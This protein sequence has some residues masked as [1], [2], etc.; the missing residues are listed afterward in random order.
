MRHLPWIV[1]VLLLGM[2]ACLL[3]ASP[4]L[5]QSDDG[6]QT[7]PPA[8]VSVILELDAPPVA[9]IY[10]AHRHLQS[11]D[12][13]GASAES[14]DAVAAVTQ[15]HLAAVE[16][17]Q[18]ATLAALDALDVEVIYRVQRV[19]NGIAV[20]VPADQ[21]AALADL[22][23]VKA[24]HPLIAKTPSNA[25]AVDL[26]GAP[27]LWLGESIS[28]TGKGVSIGIIDTGI[29]YLHTMFGG[30]GTGYTENDPTV[31]TDSNAFPSSKIVGGYDF[32]GDDYNANVSSPQYQPVPHPDPDPRDCYGFGHG[33]HVAGTA[34]G[35]GVNSDGTTY[36]GPYSATLDLSAMRIAP[37]VAP[38]ASL[39]A[40][41]VFGCSGSSEV[42]DL[43]I[44]WAVDPNQDGDLR[45]HLDVINLSLG[46]NFG[47]TYDATSVA[48]ENA[49][50]VGVVVVASAGNAGDVH[51]AM[52]R[53]G[54]APGV[55]A[56]G[57]S[58]MPGQGG[59]P[60]EGV[61]SFSARGP[62]RGANW[63]KPDIVAPG[64]DIFSARQ[65]TG[66][67]GTASSGTSMAAPVVTGG[68]A[69]LRQVRPAVGIPGWSP[70]ELKALVMNTA[71]YPLADANGNTYS[72]LRAGAGRIDL[73]AAQA[74]HLIA[75]DMEN[76]EQ[77]S[78]NFGLVEVLGRTTTVRMIQLKNKASD[79][80]R[81]TVSYTNVRTMPGVTLEVAE[82]Q[83]IDV[84]GFG[85]ASVPV[86]L[87]A[88]AGAMQRVHD[89]VR[90][91][92]EPLS[93]PGLDEVSGYVVFA[94]VQVGPDDPPNHP[95]V[96][97]PV[98]AV[99]RPVSQLEAISAP[100]RLGDA[101][102]GT[103]TLPLIGQGITGTNPPTTTV[104]L[105]GVFEL[106]HSS[107]P[108]TAVPSG[109]PVLER[110]ANADLYHV[111][112]AG[113]VTVDDVQMIY[114]AV[115]TYGIRSTPHEVIFQIQLDTDGDNL[116]EFVLSN[117]DR[118]YALLLGLTVSD[119]FVGVLEP[120]NNAAR[121][122]QGPL[123]VYPPEVYDTRLFASNAIILPLRLEDLGDAS[124]QL[125]Y[126][127]RAFSRDVDNGATLDALIDQ[128][129][130]LVADWTHGT[131]LLQA[132]PV[133]PVEPGMTL[134][135][136]YVHHALA[137]RRTQ[138]ILLLY[139]H[140]QSENPSQVVPLELGWPHNLY[141]T[142]LHKP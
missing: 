24:V 127:V 7:S 52:S 33:T 45:D 111:G 73:P 56:V 14:A 39:Y 30:P 137:Q 28:L 87:T 125:H 2:L 34:A 90:N 58:T 100:I 42:V 55:I 48:A 62:R 54:V 118:D 22:P 44:E 38:E 46:S 133:V 141:L 19:Y 17:A 79:P 15:A 35:Y 9:H 67:F 86:T 74:A 25:Q 119:D 20:R 139:L 78:V 93:L 102:S 108:L 138:G 142:P 61:A 51:Y 120:Y 47:D 94:P 91:T 41:K 3:F 1:H 129:P 63:L 96:H 32:V 31:I 132:P 68:M 123:N 98:Y 112:V 36:S 57:A 130:W 88:V 113:P 99:P 27:Q 109:D 6:A 53:P 75:F 107:P 92:D 114:F 135:I 18:I 140:N 85:Y 131:G 101:P 110:Y 8:R 26:V 12:A 134:T 65:G 37:G 122:I 11:Q 126:R 23:G 97:V 81:V 115:T 60:N 106:Q 16:D 40:L 43:A 89:P 95:A 59:N 128:T 121:M 83:V 105:A 124:H 103:I 117:R 70:A 80:I 50:R 5:A 76:P 69:L 136:P 77:V 104:S 72:L 13:G 71:A 116:P 29:D 66:S 10:A 4:G 84:P 64:Q 49:A 82:G 21:V